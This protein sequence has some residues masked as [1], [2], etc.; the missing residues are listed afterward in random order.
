MNFENKVNE[1]MTQERAQD[2]FGKENN[3]SSFFFYLCNAGSRNSNG[4]EEL[5]SRMQ[6]DLILLSQHS[7]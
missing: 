1:R 4:R 2:L 5:A 6:C 7:S 3:S